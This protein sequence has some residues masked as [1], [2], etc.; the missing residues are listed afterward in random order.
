MRKEIKQAFE[1]I[2]LLEVM[3]DQIK[4][5]A[6]G[7]RKKLLHFHEE[8]SPRRG[9]INLDVITGVTTGF[10]KSVSKRVK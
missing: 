7:L 10:R 8:V 6:S 2:D 4:I 1:E 9:K 5:K 3:A